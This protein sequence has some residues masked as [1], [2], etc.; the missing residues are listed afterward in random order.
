VQR[1]PKCLLCTATSAWFGTPES[2]GH[3]RATSP[4]VPRTQEDAQED[5]AALALEGAEARSLGGSPPGESLRASAVDL[6]QGADAGERDAPGGAG[7]PGPPLGRAA[8]VGGADRG[9]AAGAAT[10][11]TL[12]GAARAIAA[13]IAGITGPPG[14][15]Q[16]PGARD[17]GGGDG[18]AAGT[19][20]SEGSRGNGAGAPSGAAAHRLD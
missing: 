16:A 14:E 3:L 5:S 12:A 17:G 1:T 8:A 18:A 9:A 19:A 4:R 7:A 10:A 11:D 6:T 15:A 13:G 2:C 20:H